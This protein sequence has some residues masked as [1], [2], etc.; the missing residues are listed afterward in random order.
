MSN[1]RLF[2]LRS[3][4]ELAI[5]SIGQNLPLSH[6]VGRYGL[7]DSDKSRYESTTS[8]NC[9]RLPTAIALKISQC[10]RFL[11]A[12]LPGV[13]HMPAAGDD[14]K[15]AARVFYVGA[16]RATHRLVITLSGSAQFGQRIT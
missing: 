13:G 7:G 2:D 5:R 14:E 4:S 10:L 9:Q 1:F 12:A 3:V 6:H 16:T 11:V 15:E 8:I